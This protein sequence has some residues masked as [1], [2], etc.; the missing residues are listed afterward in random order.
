MLLAAREHHV[1]QHRRQLVA[2]AHAAGVA[3]E[4]FV[5]GQLGPAGHFAEANELRVIADR[6]DHV[7]IGGFKHLVGHDVLVRVAGTLRRHAGDEVVGTQVRQHRHLRIEQGHVDVL[8]LAAGVAVAQRGL[9]RDRGVQAGE[10][11]GD[12]DADFLRPAARAVVPLS[13]HA[14]QPAHALHGVVVAGAVA[15]GPCLAKAGD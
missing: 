6:Q 4:A 15:V 12:G 8:A 7:A 9:D 1:A 14:H 5:A 11:I 13:R 10:Q 2:V 3:H